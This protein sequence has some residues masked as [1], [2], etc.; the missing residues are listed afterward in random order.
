MVPNDHDIVAVYGGT[1]GFKPSASAVLTQTVEKAATTTTLTSTPNPSSYGEAVTFTT[2]VTSNGGTPDGVVRFKQGAKTLGAATLSGGAASLS[3]S[4]M[5]ANDHAI[6][7]F[8]GGNRTFATSRSTT[9]TQTVNSATTTTTVSAAPNPSTSGQMVTFTA[10]VQSATGAVPTGG[11]TFMD[12]A[13]TLATVALSDGS[14]SYSTGALAVGS[15]S[16][17]AVYARTNNFG[18]SGGTTTETV[19]EAYSH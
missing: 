8:Y 2:T 16:I 17:K 3:F 18:G 15:H 5:F 11:V 13:A 9:Q 10:Q 1:P 4:S 12:G 14:A 7:A 19:T 6:V